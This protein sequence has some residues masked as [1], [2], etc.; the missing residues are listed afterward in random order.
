MAIN[1]ILRKNEKGTL[2]RPVK[3]LSNNFKVVL[4]KNLKVYQYD[5][6]IIDPARPEDEN[7][8]PSKGIKHG[9]CRL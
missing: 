3:L 4:K 1:K 2:G 9:F 7:T 6:A 5:L 8:V